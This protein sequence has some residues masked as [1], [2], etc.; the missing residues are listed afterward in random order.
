MFYFL[1]IDGVLN[2]ESDW[3]KSFTVNNECLKFF[4]KL[5]AHDS[6]PHIIFS[7]TWRAG[8][9]N[10]GVMS[11]NGDSL[12]NL[13]MEYGIT[14]EDSTP[15]SRKTRQEEIE[16]YIRRHNISTYIILDDDES[17][18]PWAERIN[19]Y[20]TDYRTGFTAKDIKKI[21]KRQSLEFY[22]HDNE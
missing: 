15:I 20:L 5:I 11:T 8:Y 12:S 18:F 22:K 9:S 13:L 1:D 14:I 2:K 16:Y 6:D 17:L 4:S 7:S 19:L 21:L 10:T 3:K